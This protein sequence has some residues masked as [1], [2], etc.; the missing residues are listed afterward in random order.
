MQ[1][2]DS[3]RCLY[4][5]GVLLFLLAL[6][7]G[8]IMPLLPNRRMGLSGHLVGLFGALLLIAFGSLWNYA[9]LSPRVGNWVRWL[10]IFGT[11]SNLVTSVIS[12]TFA[13]SRLTPLAGSGH[14]AAPWQENL[15]TFGLVSSSI[16]MV[17]VGLLVLWGLRRNRTTRGVTNEA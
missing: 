14:L 17:T 8:M 7:T 4:S 15:V 16:A 12:A 2:D 5:A 11:Y 6:V 13:T 1:I 10:A 9:A 3:R